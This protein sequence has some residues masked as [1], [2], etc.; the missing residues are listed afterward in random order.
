MKMLLAEVSFDLGFKYTNRLSGD[1]LS[2]KHSSI[3]VRSMSDKEKTFITLTLEFPDF[4]QVHGGQWMH[5]SGK[6]VSVH[7]KHCFKQ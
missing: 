1:R 5:D 3:F 6:K 7:F 4:A 2:D